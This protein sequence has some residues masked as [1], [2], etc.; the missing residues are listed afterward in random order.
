MLGFRAGYFCGGR[1]PVG[2]RTSDPG[3]DWSV[4]VDNWRLAIGDWPSAIGRLRR[5]DLLEPLVAGER[6]FLLRGLFEDL[7]DDHVGVDALGGGGEVRQ[8][9]VPQDRVGQRLDVLGGDVRAAVQ[10]RA[11]L[12][13]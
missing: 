5:E 8:D 7:L 1:R 2:T 10:K 9:A 6:P 4:A 11:G 12:A 3:L 13:A